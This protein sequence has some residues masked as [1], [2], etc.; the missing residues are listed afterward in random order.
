MLVFFIAI[1]RFR[2]IP[3]VTVTQRVKSELSRS[4]AGLFKDDS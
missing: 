2:A 1:F 3:G 4:E